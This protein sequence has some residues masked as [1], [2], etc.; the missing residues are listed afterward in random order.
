[1]FND[2]SAMLTSAPKIKPV[3]FKCMSIWTMK[4]LEKLITIVLSETE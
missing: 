3:D 4:I 2:D 1:L